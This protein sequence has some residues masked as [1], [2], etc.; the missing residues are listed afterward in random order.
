MQRATGTHG[1]GLPRLLQARPPLGNARTS[2][3]SPRHAGG[4]ITDWRGA[5]LT[6]PKDGGA[7]ACSGEVLAAGDARAHAQALELLA[8]QR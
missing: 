4:T 3:P 1:A 5:P 2:C 6:W 8:W 7:A